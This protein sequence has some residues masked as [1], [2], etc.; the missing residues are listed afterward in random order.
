MVLIRLDD[1]AAHSHGPHVVGVA[2]PDGPKRVSL[3]QGVLPTEIARTANRGRLRG[4]AVL[5]Q[6][7]CQIGSGIVSTAVGTGRRVFRTLR[8][9]DGKAPHGL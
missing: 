7:G 4:P 2:S 6:V 9:V 8:V 1:R 3:H 5:S